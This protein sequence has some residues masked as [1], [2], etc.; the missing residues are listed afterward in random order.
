MY[1]QQFA[2][3]I[4]VNRSGY[5]RKLLAKRNPEDIPK[6]KANYPMSLNAGQQHATSISLPEHSLTSDIMAIRYLDDVRPEIKFATSF[7]THNMSKPTVALRKHINHLLSYLDATQDMSLIIKPSN[8]NLQ[9]YIDASYAIHPESR[10]H[11]GIAVCLG[12][13][14]Y[15]FHC[16]SSAIKVVCRS[17]TEAEIHAANEVSSD[18]LHAID[19]LTELKHLQD[20]VPFYED[21]QAVIHMMVRQEVNFQTKSKHVRV[22]YDFLRQQVAENMIVFIYIPTD[23]QL[24]DL[25]TKPLIGDKLVYFRD[26]LMGIVPHKP[27]LAPDGE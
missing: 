4:A 6:S 23:L 3:H 7:L 21:N 17:S 24:A 27:Y 12:E 11:Y 9:V 15:A 18:V 16:K 14:G 5:I 20:P 13:Q 1:I 25:L 10:S 8:L 22:R 2:D 19:L 26:C